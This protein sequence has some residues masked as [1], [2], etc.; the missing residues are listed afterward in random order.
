MHVRTF[1]LA[2]TC[3]SLGLLSGCRED[4][5]LSFP[6]FPEAAART[7]GSVDLDLGPFA[8]WAASSVMDDHDPQTGQVRQILQKLKSVKVR[9]YAISPDR[10]PPQAEL[11][12]LR[13]Q[14]SGPGWTPLVQTHERGGN[15]D[16]N[17]YIA[18]DEH[19]VH[20]LAVLAT[21]PREVTIVNVIG[22][23]ERS[24]VA[25]LTELLRN[26]RSRRAAGL[27]QWSQE[28]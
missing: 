1:A 23:I 9:S 10:P 17:I 11:A 4:G 14:L 13:R 3:L 24:D 22:T 16:V 20:G 6:P 19:A 7:T 26:S 8:L 5:E 28:D 2:L 21:S 18:Q 25:R 27:P 12:S 15:E